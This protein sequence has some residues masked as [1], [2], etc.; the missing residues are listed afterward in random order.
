MSTDTPN[1]WWTVDPATDPVAYEREVLLGVALADGRI[2]PSSVP[3]WR[4]HLRT[5]PE[6]HGAMLA[7]LSAPPRG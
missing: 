3:Q 7:L 4:E 6:R 2:N 5:D 1:A